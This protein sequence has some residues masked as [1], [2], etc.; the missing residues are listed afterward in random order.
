M[1]TLALVT[2]LTSS[3]HPPS[4]FL[5]FSIHLLMVAAVPPPPPVPAGVGNYMYKRFVYSL[6]ADNAVTAITTTTDAVVGSHVVG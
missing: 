3:T 5:Q 2:E 6:T 4:P 1:L